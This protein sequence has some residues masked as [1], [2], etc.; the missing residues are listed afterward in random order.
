MFVVKSTK[1][2]EGFW[3]SVTL[4]CVLLPLFV[5]MSSKLIRPGHAED[6]H[7]NAIKL[8]KRLEYA[9]RSPK[10][11]VVNEVD[12]NPRLDCIS[13]FEFVM[14]DSVENSDTT[15]LDMSTVDKKPKR[16]SVTFEHMM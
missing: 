12:F 3:V 15:K 16:A 5:P 8:K 1:S 10:E 13:W 11:R 9:I 2:L 14:E 4:S 7:S 6:D